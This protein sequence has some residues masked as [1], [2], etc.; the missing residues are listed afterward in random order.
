MNIKSIIIVLFLAVSCYGQ[1]EGFCQSYFFINGKVPIIVPENKEFVLR[2]LYVDCVDGQWLI[3]IGEFEIWLAGRHRANNNYVS[4]M[5]EFP[6]GTAVVGS[7]KT[8]YLWESLDKQE[9]CYT[10]IGYFRTL[11]D[12]PKADLTEDCIVDFR[13]FALLASEWLNS[14]Y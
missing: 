4:S 1:K 7:G 8:I 13:D 5:R 2:R 10:L 3:S 6:D 11:P 9:I 12:C 14:P